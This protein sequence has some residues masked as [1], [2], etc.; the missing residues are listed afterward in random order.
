M[1]DGFYSLYI[2]A[3][4]VYWIRSDNIT[5]RIAIEFSSRNR[6]EKLIMEHTPDD[7]KLDL[8]R[9]FQQK[10]PLTSADQGINKLDP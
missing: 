4:K 1:P 5:Q 10:V 9:D 6:E 2:T 3:G 8:E 7:D